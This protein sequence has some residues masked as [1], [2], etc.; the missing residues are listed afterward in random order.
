[1]SGFT[2]IPEHSLSGATQILQVRNKGS[3]NNTKSRQDHTVWNA[4]ESLGKCLTST[5]WLTGEARRGLAW[6]I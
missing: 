4:N 2:N 6:R 3:Q 5:T 1:M